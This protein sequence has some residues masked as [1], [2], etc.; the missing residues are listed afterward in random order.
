M[1]E[2]AITSIVIFVLQTLIFIAAASYPAPSKLYIG[3]VDLMTDRITLWSSSHPPIDY[4]AGVSAF[5][6]TWRYALSGVVS[7]G[8]SSYNYVI[9]QPNKVLSF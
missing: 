3:K 7:T 2:I 6:L 9:N 5:N 8:L 4:T 1:G